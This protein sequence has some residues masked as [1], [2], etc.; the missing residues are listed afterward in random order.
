MAVRLRRHRQPP[1]GGLGPYL[2]LA[3]VSQREPRPRQLL[4]CQSC[5]HVG[6]VLGLVLGTAQHG[7]SVRRAGQACV[8]ARHDRVEAQHTGAIQDRR[9]LDALIAPQA[10]VRRPA[11]GVLGEEVRH[12]RLAERL[13]E[14]PDVEGDAQDIGGSAGVPGVLQRAAPPGAGTQRGRRL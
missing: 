7:G 12:D 14:I 10:G 2:G 4:W 1:L 5:Q 3:A 6:L 8:V 11:G 13:G 9:E